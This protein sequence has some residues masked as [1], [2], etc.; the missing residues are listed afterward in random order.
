VLI[1]ATLVAA[2]MRRNAVYSDPI[3]FWSDAVEKSPWKARPHTNLGQAWFTAGE[4][5]RAIEQFR[6][7]LRLDPLNPE[8]QR[9]LLA[10]W[11]RKTNRDMGGQVSTEGRP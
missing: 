6:A 2:T 9:N 7:A 10:A 1:V 4:L 5:D 3:A 11:A 8:A